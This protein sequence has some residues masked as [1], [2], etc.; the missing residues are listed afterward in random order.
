VL[1][2]YSSWTSIESFL[3]FSAL[4]SSF[5]VFDDDGMLLSA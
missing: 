1:A 5:S 2:L 4:A 3:V